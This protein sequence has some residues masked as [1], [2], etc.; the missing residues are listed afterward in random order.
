MTANHGWYESCKMTSMKRVLSFLVLHCACGSVSA[1]PGDS[2]DVSTGGRHDVTGSDG[3][4]GDAGF[5]SAGGCNSEQ[6]AIACLASPGLMYFNG[7]LAVDDAN[8]S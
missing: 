1:N 3:K 8:R 5:D 7:G 4:T 6:A 2:G